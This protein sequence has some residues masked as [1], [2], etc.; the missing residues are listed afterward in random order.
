MTTNGWRLALAACFATGAIACASRGR[1]E[2]WMLLRPPEV[3]DAAYPRGY[4][5]LPDAPMAGW[6]REATFATEGRCEAARQ[7][8]VQVAI[9]RGR[10][11]VGDFAPDAVIFSSPTYPT[12]AS[13]SRAG[14][15][16]TRAC[17][18]SAPT[19]SSAPRAQPA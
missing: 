12:T 2:S 19:T 13:S 6:S 8:R 5:L 3:A 11:A 1:A 18:K 15:R 17:V 9:E 7:E 16:P 4:R 14:S 10:S